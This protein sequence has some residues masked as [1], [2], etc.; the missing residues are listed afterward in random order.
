LFRLKKRT[1][2]G[3]DSDSALQENATVE[4]GDLSE[5]VT[6]S[7]NAVRVDTVST[8]LGE[9]FAAPITTSFTSPNFGQ[10]EAAAARS[11]LLR[12]LLRRSGR[13]IDLF[14]H[15]LV[16][17]LHHVNHHT[18]SNLHVL[19]SA[20]RLA[21]HDLGAG[22]DH[23]RLSGACSCLDDQGGIGGGNDVPADMRLAAVSAEER[24]HRNEKRENETSDSLH[25]CFPFCRSLTSRDHVGSKVNVVARR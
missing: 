6:V 10:I 19:Q 12:C 11:A 23:E 2:I 21:A 20:L 22:G 15:Q 4:L 3:V 9:V 1:G 16:A 7:V 5:T 25:G 14:R 8:R 18:I 24:G 17:M 13:Q